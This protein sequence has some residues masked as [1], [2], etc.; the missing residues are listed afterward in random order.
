M[1]APAGGFRLK[2]TPKAMEQREWLRR[3]S[4]RR[5]KKLTKTLRF[6]KDDPKHPGLNSHKWDKLKGKAPD[7]G[8]MWVAYLENHT[9]SAW[10]IF[11][12]FDSRDP[13]VLYVTS[14]E[15]HS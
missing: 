6:L 15:P 10:R 5:F 12:F 4:P 8:D 2:L 1:N 13:G 3:S 9:P 7:R 11:Y 14:I